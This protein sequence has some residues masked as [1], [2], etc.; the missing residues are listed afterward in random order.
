[1]RD[2]VLNAVSG[3][4]GGCDLDVGKGCDVLDVAGD[5]RCRFR[6][7]GSHQV[8]SRSRSSRRGGATLIR[9]FGTDEVNLVGGEGHRIPN[10]VDRQS[11]TRLHFLDTHLLAWPPSLQPSDGIGH[12][13]M[14]PAYRS[15]YLSMMRVNTA[16]LSDRYYMRVK[17]KRRS[18]T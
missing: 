17:Q 15:V 14:K 10:D 13:D 7:G 9:C 2:L 8:K 12:P 16:P 11:L 5:R 6:G 18:V 4:S 1:M 3:C